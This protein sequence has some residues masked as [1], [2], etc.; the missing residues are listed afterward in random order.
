VS[1]YTLTSAS[2][3]GDPRD[4]VLRGSY[5]GKTWAVVDQ[6]AGQTFPWRQQTRA[7]AVAHPGRYAYYRLEV[8]AASAA[9][10]VSLAEVELLATPPA[11]CTQTITGARSAPVHVTAGLLCLADAHLTGSLTVD[12][13]A[14]VRVVNSTIEGP[15]R[16]TGA[17]SVVLLGATV[18]GPVEITATTGEVSLEHSTVTGPV[19]VLDGT[20]G[21]L[22]A[23]NTVDGPLTCTGNAPAPVNNGFPN[24]VTGPRTGQATA[25]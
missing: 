10:G 11:A 23:A 25:L 9:A 22:L 15:V 2:S 18:T 21:T 3:G 4:W 6:R 5:D 17:A 12:A 20:G 14:S 16:A 13:G 7:F 1:Y 24:T 19:R 8:T